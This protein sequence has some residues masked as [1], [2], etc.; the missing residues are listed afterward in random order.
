MTSPQTPAVELTALT[1]SFANG[2]SAVHAVRGI[3]LTIHQGE[4]VAVLGPNGAGKTTTLD[5]VLGLTEPTGGRA[6]VLGVRPRDAV[7]GGRVSAV[8]QTGGLLRDLTVRETVRMIAS[9]YAVHAGVDAVIARADLTA[10]AHRKVS[11]C[12][13]GEQQRLRFAL[14]LLPDPEVLVLD[15]P[16]AGMDVAARRAF[17]DV[18]QAEAAAGRTILFATHYLEEADAFADRI[19][20]M[21]RGRV[22]AD[23]PTAEIRAR[24]TGRTVTARL[25]R[26]SAADTL[27]ALRGLDVVQEVT[28]DGDR[29]TV[30]S[31][32]SDH[33]ARTLLSRPGSR[34]LEITTGSL[35]TAFVALTSHPTDP[36][37]APF[38][39]VTTEQEDAA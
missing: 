22:V 6:L 19:V 12:S 17:W 36:T 27:E 11:K 5:I 23:A 37:D 21:A 2:G 24:A 14:A 13:G 1:K 32:D 7:R 26:S 3:D 39:T 25:D 28:T 4:V 18:M 20:L 29:V 33:V 31:T 10:V 38:T 15:E 16:T 35:E 34:D 9:T 8:L 30:T